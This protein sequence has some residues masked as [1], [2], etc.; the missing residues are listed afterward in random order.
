M[1]A[2]LFS[3]NQ[4]MKKMMPLSILT[5]LLFTL[6]TAFAQLRKIP[7]EVTNSFS[8][9]YAGATSVEW[10]D[11][12]TGFTAHF[13]LNDTDYLATFSNKGAWESTEQS[14]TESELPEEVEQGFQKSKYADW[15]IREVHRIELPGEQIQYRLEVRSGDIKRRN[16]SFSSEGRLLKD[17]LTI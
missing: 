10:K 6:N 11:K 7:A 12:L 9:K 8:E 3:K 14:I 16:L 17:N 15:D 1:F 13:S 4:D 2:Y 5:L